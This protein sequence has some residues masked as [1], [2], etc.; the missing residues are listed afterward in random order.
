MDAITNCES[1]NNN[2]Q[3]LGKKA[4]REFWKSVNHPQKSDVYHQGDVD[5]KGDVRESNMN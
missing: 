1:N 4:L 3:F 5:F 2:G